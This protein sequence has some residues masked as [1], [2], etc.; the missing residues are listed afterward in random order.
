MLYTTLARKYYGCSS[1]FIRISKILLYAIH[2]ALLV[3]E[4]QEHVVLSGFQ[5]YFCML[6]TTLFFMSFINHWLFYQDFKDTFVCYTQLCSCGVTRASSCFI[7]ISKILLYAIHNIIAFICSLLVVVLSGFQR[8]FCMLYTTG[9]HTKRYVPW[10]FYQDFKDT[11]VCYTQLKL[12]KDLADAG[13]F[14]R[15]SK[16][17]LYAIH[18]WISYLAL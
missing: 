17:L 12:R 4:L 5:R 11:F 6:Y 10:L 14:I 15:I 16:I 7:R 3:L 13:C 9:Y 8:Y 2:N 18:N 1:C